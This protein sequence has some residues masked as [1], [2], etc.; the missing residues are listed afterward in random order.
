MELTDNTF[1][2]IR[3]KGQP[4]DARGAIGDIING[5]QVLGLSSTFRS[6][7]MAMVK[8]D[9]W[10]Q[11]ARTADPRCRHSPLPLLQ[12]GKLMTPPK[13]DNVVPE[14]SN[15][16]GLLVSL[17]SALADVSTVTRTRRQVFDHAAPTAK[18]DDAVNFG[19]C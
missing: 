18:V 7:I 12:N 10:D 5:F 19:R 16:A 1:C 14:P 9:T 11:Q 4:A 17:R 15:F 8:V 13:I 3:A 6:A 2:G